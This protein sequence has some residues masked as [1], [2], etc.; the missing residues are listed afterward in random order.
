MRITVTSPAGTYRRVRRSPEITIPL[1]REENHHGHMHDIV[2]GIHRKLS[3]QFL[4]TGIEYSLVSGRGTI[5][6]DF[7]FR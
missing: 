6:G 2:F 3:R 1:K 5:T 7:A 4:I